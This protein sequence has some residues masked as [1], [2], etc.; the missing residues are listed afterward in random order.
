M[1]DTSFDSE[2]MEK[3]R[4]VMNIDLAKMARH[5]EHARE[6]KRLEQKCGELERE[7][8]DLVARLSV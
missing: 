7:R 1:I 2:T 8:D 3:F 5:I 4:A 6:I